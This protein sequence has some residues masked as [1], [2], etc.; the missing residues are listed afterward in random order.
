MET[1]TASSMNIDSPIAISL[2]A[3]AEGNCPGRFAGWSDDGINVKV[4][5][6]LKVGSV[7]KVESDD[8]LM[9]AE[10]RDCESDGAEYSAGLFLLEWMEKAELERIKRE[11]A[12]EPPRKLAA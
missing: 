6:G 7:V 2:L 5:T 10:V 4:A 3:H 11:L 12:C 9:V 1:R 8:D